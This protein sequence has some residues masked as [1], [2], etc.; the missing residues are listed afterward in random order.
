MSFVLVTP[1]ALGFP[2]L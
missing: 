1:A 2:R